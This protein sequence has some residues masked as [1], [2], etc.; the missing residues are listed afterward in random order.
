MC[1]CMYV[2]YCYGVIPGR[3]A[4]QTWVSKILKTRLLHSK[5]PHT[6]RTPENIEMARVSM[7][8][9][10]QRSAHKPSTALEMSNSSV[11]NI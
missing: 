1:V 9:S 8:H 7:L 11:R 5:S 6:F 10:L 3:K 4:T 2:L